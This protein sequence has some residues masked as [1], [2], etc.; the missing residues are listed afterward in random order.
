MKKLT[1]AIP[2]LPPDAGG[3]ERQAFLQL[4]L[5]KNYFDLDVFSSS[6]DDYLLKNFNI[7]FYNH[8]NYKSFLN[9]EILALKIFIS[10]IKKGVFFH[11][12]ILYLHQINL[13]TYLCLFISTFTKKKIFIKLANSGQKFD[14]VTFSNRYRFL[15]FLKYF[16]SLPNVII[17]C[18]SPQIREDFNLHKIESKN[19]IEFRNGVVFDN[20]ETKQF[21][22]RSIFYIGRLE[23]I[24]N[25]TY[26]L[27]LAKRLKEFNFTIIGDGSLRNS[28]EK[29]SYDLKNVTFLGEVKHDKID[30]SLAEWLI[31][32]SDAEGM[33]NSLLEGIAAGRGI[34]C[35]K[36]KSNEFVEKFINKYV[37]ISEDIDKTINQ[38]RLKTGEE[39]RV[40]D[41]FNM[42]KIESVVND[43]CD[44]FSSLD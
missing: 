30:L 4:K 1:V 3:M 41:D 15:P 33:S 32:P 17:L 18:I 37:W 21:E 11:N 20:L 22:K 6:S 44:I 16:L 29:E 26:I 24:K 28:L 7:A 27:K 2:T 10:M 8:K 35:K 25:V 13:L 12:G 38:I 5:L 19:L 40:R 36:I 42:Y 31:L 9:K 14:Y 34:I 39:S 43:L 23:P